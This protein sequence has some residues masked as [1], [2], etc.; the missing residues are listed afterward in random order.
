MFY[1][2]YTGDDNQSQMEEYTPP[3]NLPAVSV[4]IRRHEPRKFIDWHTAPR[5]H[6]IVEGNSFSF[7]F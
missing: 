1:R 5:K 3:D 4:V 2:L 6:F 7:K